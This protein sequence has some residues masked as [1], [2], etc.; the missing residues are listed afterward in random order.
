MGHKGLK[1]LLEM[2]EILQNYLVVF[3]VETVLFAL[4]PKVE[5]AFGEMSFAQPSLFG[6]ILLLAVPISAW[7]I[8]MAANR[9]LAFMGL[10]AAV[11]FLGSCLGGTAP[12]RAVFVM[13]TACYLF[14]SLYVR[15][16]LQSDG[17]GALGAAAAAVLGAGTFFLCAYLGA[18][19]S[20]A[21][22]LNA[23]LLYT[24]LFFIHIYLQRLEQ[25]IRF[26]RASN[27][28]IPARKMLMQGGGL[29]AA[30]SL[31]VVMILGAAADDSLMNKAVTWLKEGLWYLGRGIL[32]CLGMLLRL[33]GSDGGAEQ[34]EEAPA[35]V[36]QL[37]AGEAAASPFWLE[38]LYKAIE[39]VILGGC[40]FL[41]CFALY[42][43]FLAALHRFYEK[44]GETREDANDA[45]EIRERIEK[46]QKKE[47]GERR[48][49]L[50]ART[51][52]EK[53]RKAFIRTIRRTEGF[54]NPDGTNGGKARKDP[55]KEEARKGLVQGKTARELSCLMHLEEG[56]E[57]AGEE[58][59]HKE[60]LFLELVQLYEKARYAGGCTAKEA[61]RAG[62]LADMLSGERGPSRFRK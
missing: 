41:I 37:A 27:A 3:C 49:L 13:L 33:F 61:R 48:R 42:K 9:F 36:P 1:R 59:C 4:F 26:N 45:E 44:R 56:K 43:L 62:Q 10:H 19:E 30:C 2:M 28:H 15:F 46:G 6:Q 23:A 54:R 51:E 21:R 38:L 39:L 18:D 5:S 60:A 8:R 12:Q 58:A 34:I 24:F 40:L 7:L 20:C 53:I 52:E 11:L 35:A 32:W 55:W 57:K 25:F 14:R 22:I 17:E 16:K 31:I 50:F 29:S 47:R